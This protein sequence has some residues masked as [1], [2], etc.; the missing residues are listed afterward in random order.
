MVTL[1]H[2]HNIYARRKGAGSKKTKMFVNDSHSDSSA[3]TVSGKGD[4]EH[5]VDIVRIDDDVEET[6]TFIKMDI[7]GAEQDALKGCENTIRKHHPKLAI[8]IYHGYEDIWKIPSIIYEMNP[9]YKFYIRHNGGNLVPTE[10]V[11][12]CKP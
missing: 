4:N 1:P 10:F 5:T 2:W 12:L 11:L 9:D 7:E 3:N 6:P 8:C